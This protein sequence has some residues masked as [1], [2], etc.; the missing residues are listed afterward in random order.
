MARMGNRLEGDGS[1][2]GEEP[3]RPCA[4]GDCGAPGDYRAPRSPNDLGAY[5]WFCLEHVRQYNARWDFFDGMNSEEIEAFRRDDMTG[6][7]P[8]WPMAAGRTFRNVWNSE[9][10]GDLLGV[11]GD[12]RPKGPEANGG[13]HGALPADDRDALAVLN[14]DPMATRADIKVRFKEL[15]KRHHPDVNGGDRAA[16]ERLKR[17]IKAYR[18]LL[19][20]R[21]A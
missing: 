4:R 6:H 10:L 20:S 12:D 2:D 8:T 18:R 17:V 5:Y 11:F 14:L 16:E 1:G 21:P 19:G 9:G 7:R 15:V 3:A 13:M